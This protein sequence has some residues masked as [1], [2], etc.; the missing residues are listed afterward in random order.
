MI[1]ICLLDSLVVETVL[2]NG[3]LLL[4]IIIDIP[5]SYSGIYKPYRCSPGWYCRHCITLCSFR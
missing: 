2:E 5:V 1:K 4:K 3:V